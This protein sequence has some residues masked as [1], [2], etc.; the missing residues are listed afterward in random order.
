MCL[1]RQEIIDEM[2][3]GDLVVLYLIRWVTFHICLCYFMHL[4]VTT[5]FF[6]SSQQVSHVPNDAE[7]CDF[8]EQSLDAS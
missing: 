4:T 8:E 1:W 7:F 3:W 2:V 5:G 6:G